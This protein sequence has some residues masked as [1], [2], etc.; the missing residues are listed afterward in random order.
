MSLVRGRAVGG[1]AGREADSRPLAP[2]TSVSRSRGA[3][4]EPPARRQRL[5]SEQS[6]TS[7]GLSQDNEKLCLVARL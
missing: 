2:R 1:R 4:G 7:L 5:F 6:L 3:R